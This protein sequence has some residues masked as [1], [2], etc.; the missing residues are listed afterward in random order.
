MTIDNDTLIAVVGF[1][2]TGAYLDMRL[3]VVKLHR[4]VSTWEHCHIKCKPEDAAI[5]AEK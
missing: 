3:L 4:R 2:V 5:F 1:I